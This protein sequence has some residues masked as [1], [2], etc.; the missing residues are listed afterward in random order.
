MRDCTKDQTSAGTFIKIIG[1]GGGLFLGALFAAPVDGIDV[2][3]VRSWGA[4]PVFNELNNNWQA[5]GKVPLSID[6][7]LMLVES[8]TYEDLAATGADVVWLSDPAGGPQQYSNAEIDAIMQYASEGHSIL[9]TFLV[10]QWVAADN[11]GLAPIF[12][13][14]EEIDYNTEEVSADASFDLLVEDHPLFHEVT[15]PYVTGGYINAQVPAE[16]FSWDPGDLGAARLLAQTADNRGVITLYEANA[17]HAIFVSKMVEYNGNG[18]DSQFLYNALTLA[19]SCPWDFD[20]DGTV[21]AVDLLLLLVHWGPCAGCP[22]DFDG[23]GNVGASDLLA[24]LANWGPC[25]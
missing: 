1:L 22:A 21:G 7:S 23:N 24:L 13:L 6:T 2:A 4:V 5:Y 14:L 11:R 25:P 17:Y 10:F 20:D 18:M 3:V 15:D 12:G 9:G 19:P 16:D 8:F